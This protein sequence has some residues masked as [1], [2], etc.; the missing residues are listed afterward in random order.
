[1]GRTRLLRGRSADPVLIHQWPL[2]D[3]PVN[4]LAVGP[5]AELAAAGTMDGSIVLIRIP[6]GGPVFV[7][8]DAHPGGVSRLAF[9]PDGRTLA[10]GGLARAVRLWWRDG[11]DRRPIATLGRATGPILGLDFA[12]ACRSRAEDRPGGVAEGGDRPEV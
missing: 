12:P 5:G 10:S 9:G 7:L 6:D 4:A 8:P 3:G 1:D 2:D 11:P